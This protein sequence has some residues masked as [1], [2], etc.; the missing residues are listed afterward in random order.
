VDKDNISGKAPSYFEAFDI[1]I[2]TDLNPDGLNIINTAT[3]VIRRPFYA[4]GVH[5]LYGF[6]FS[7][8][9]QHEYTV[10]REEGNKHT[11][12]GSET[13]T[14]TVVSVRRK[15][16]KAAS[17]NRIEVITKQERYSTWFLASDAAKLPDE[18][19]KS[20]RRLKAASPLL[21]CFRALWEFQTKFGRLPGH[22]LEDLKNF[23]ELAQKKHI[24]L[25][26]PSETLRSE[27]LRAF[28]QNI[29]SEIA[30]VTAQLGGQLAQDVINVLGRRQQPIQNMVLFDGDT[31][32]SPM[33]ALHPDG[34]LGERLLPM[35][36]S[37]MDSSYGLSE[38]KNYGEPESHRGS[39]VPL[40]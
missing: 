23:T 9:I 34:P 26:L 27:I 10:E 19:L 15:V 4:A 7:D 36:Q 21:S 40:N 29:G 35:T 18:Y 16:E 17:G 6:I 24:A 1:I 5:G 30:P 3:R 37:A 39:P 25:S 33:Y 20:K 32:T 8:L 38:D 22:G 2:A 28:I 11:P 14:R 31:M 13:R 12:L